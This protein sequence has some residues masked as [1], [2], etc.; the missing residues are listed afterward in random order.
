METRK[1]IAAVSVAS[2]ISFHVTRASP[3]KLPEAWYYFERPADN[4][5]RS[6]KCASGT[7]QYSRDET[8]WPRDAATKGVPAVKMAVGEGKMGMVAG[9]ISLQSG[10]LF[11]GRALKKSSGSSFSYPH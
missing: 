2:V 3:N 4:I 11:V 5:E 6:P 1:T 7:I 9:R 10:N 8:I